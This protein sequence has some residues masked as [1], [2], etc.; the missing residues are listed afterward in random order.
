M[1][2]EMP[3]PHREGVDLPLFSVRTSRRCIL[4]RLPGIFILLMPA[5][6][7]ASADDIVWTTGRVMDRTGKQPVQG[8]VVAV[9]DAK[10]RVVDY[11]KTGADGS[12]ALAVPKSAINLPK[13]RGGFLHRVSKGVNSAVAG[14]G[15]LIGGPI[16]A[17]IRAA[18]SVAGGADPLTRAGIGA[19]AGLANSIVDIVT[20]TGATRKA[21]D[22]NA[23]G[24]IAV[25]VAAD[26][27]DGVSG[28]SRVYWMQ[29][30]L[31]RVGGREQ[32]AIVA[33]LDPIRLGEEGSRQGSSLTSD[34]LSFTEAR[35][36]PEIVERGREVTVTVRFTRPA[37]PRAPA[38]IVARNART[39]RMHELE[40]IGGDLYQCSFT[41]G[42]KDP[43]HDQSIT[44]I[45]YAEQDAK[46]GRDPSVERALIRAG[47][48]DPRRRFVYNPLAVV[49]RNRVELTLTVVEPP[50]SR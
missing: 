46:P 11:V 39:G 44:V 10:N 25:R 24:V 41:V 21:L 2:L 8:A 32:R 29:E 1:R 47:Y 45:A 15:G 33:W 50:R 14:A 19:V 3:V 18:A 30:E 42:P 13:K 43:L 49:S 37:E 6:M 26:G 48:W 5:T 12:Y 16:K 7:P 22:R 17:G 23:P 28:L 38:V 27:R 35:I 34:L 36:S 31:Y 4:F 40:P 9:Y 20:G